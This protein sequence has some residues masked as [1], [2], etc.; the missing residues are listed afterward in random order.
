MLLDSAEIGRFHF[1]S[2]Y[3]PDRSRRLNRITY[4]NE[5]DVRLQA[6]SVNEQC[7]EQ[8]VKRIHSFNL[9]ERD[10]F[11]VD[12]EV[13]LKHLYM[14][15]ERVGAHP[16]DNFMTFL[17]RSTILTRPASSIAA[18]SPVWNHPSASI[19]FLVFSGSLW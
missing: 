17:I 16:C 14:K 12:K 3:P 13:N 5:N 2:Y 15:L 11:S 9:F 18:I 4:S 1:F 19:A 7:R 10:V 8:G 6:V